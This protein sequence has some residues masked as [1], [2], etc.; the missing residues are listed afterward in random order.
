MKF[1]TSIIH[2]TKNG[3]KIYDKL[4]PFLENNTVYNKEECKVKDFVKNHFKP[5]NTIIF[6][7]A[8][9]IAVRLIAP[10]IKSKET[11]AAVIVID[12]LG[13]Y[14]IPILSGHIGRANEVAKEVAVI[15]KSTVIITTATDINNKFAI[16]SWG[17][18]N[19]CVIND[20]T[21]IKNV[22]IEILNDNNVGF[23]CDF[24]V[25]NHLPKGLVYGKGTKVGVVVSVDETRN[26]Y[27]ITLNVIPKIVVVGIGCRK[28]V[29]KDLFEQFVLRVLKEQN[30]SIKS[31]YAISSIDLKKNENCILSFCDKYGIDFITL[32]KEQLLT[33]DCELKE[34]EFV[35]KVAGVGNV[36]Q[37]SAIYVSENE[38]VTLQKYCENG[39]AISISKKEWECK[40]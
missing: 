40:F 2:F 11:D 8:I 30:I 3:K 34:S 26:D 14:V 35:K 21:K 33:V 13:E 9:G 23:T 25:K 17:Y 7:G 10:L 36:C 15:L 20:I 31:I 22:S 12:E 5:K 18:N 16:D 28:N 19:G 1:K 27:E 38:N 37:R 29:D 32:T 39:M 6:I 4:K 24:M